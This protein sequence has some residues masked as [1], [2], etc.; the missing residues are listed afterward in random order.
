MADSPHRETLERGFAAWNSGDVDALLATLHPEIVWEPSGLFPGLR[1][2]YEGHE[3]VRRFWRDFRD[4]W[5]WI[6]I[7]FSELRDLGPNSVL[8]HVH[9]QA[10]GRG[11]IEVEQDFGQLY[12]VRDGLLTRMHSYGTW[13]DALAAVGADPGEA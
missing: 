2:R 13:P 4:P 5:E 10:R 11:G 3:G 1:R 6:E 7:Q 12:D 8:V 9:F